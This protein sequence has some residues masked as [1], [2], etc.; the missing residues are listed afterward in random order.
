MPQ[1]VFFQIILY[2]KGFLTGRLDAVEL[3]ITG[4]QI[5]SQI[6]RV[7]VAQILFSVFLA[8]LIDMRG[9]PEKQLNMGKR[10]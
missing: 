1:L 9:L 8:D 4:L 2:G 5:H 10:L 3:Q 7:L 6:P